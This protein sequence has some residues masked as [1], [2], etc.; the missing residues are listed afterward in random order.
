MTDGLPENNPQPGATSLPPLPP[1]PT[2]GLD[3]TNLPPASPA[4]PS[5]PEQSAPVPQLATPGQVANPS[6]P[7]QFVIPS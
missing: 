5:T 6:D 3:T 1:T 2:A 4:V 7:G